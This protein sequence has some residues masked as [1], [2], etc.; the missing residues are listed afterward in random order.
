MVILGKDFLDFYK[1][2][3]DFLIMSCKLQTKEFPLFCLIVCD[4]DRTDLFPSEL[5]RRFAGNHNTFGGNIFHSSLHGMCDPCHYE[6]WS[7][8]RDLHAV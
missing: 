1:C 7:L 6:T 8:S 5:G 3:I 2:V 4:A